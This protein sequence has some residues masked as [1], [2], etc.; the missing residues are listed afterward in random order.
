MDLSDEEIRQFTEACADASHSA[1]RQVMLAAG[2]NSASGVL[3]RILLAT[4]PDRQRLIELVRS[5]IR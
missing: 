5:V 4:G 1:V 3:A 2:A